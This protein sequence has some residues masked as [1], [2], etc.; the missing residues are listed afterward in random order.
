MS[1]SLYSIFFYNFPSWKNLFQKLVANFPISLP[2]R[3][4]WSIIL[5]SKTVSPVAN[6]NN[7][8]LSLFWNRMILNLWNRKFLINLV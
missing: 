5:A 7:K 2:K 4:K 6:I 8:Y 1:T 3:L